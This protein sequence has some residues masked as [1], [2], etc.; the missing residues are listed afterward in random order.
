ML[1]IMRKLHNLMH[2]ERGCVLMLHCVAARPEDNYLVIT[3][4]YLEKTIHSYFQQGYEAVSIDE[5]G[6]RI[7]NHEKKR[8]VCFTFDDGYL[9]VLTLAYPLLKAWQIPF[10]VYMTRDFYRGTAKPHWNPE[11]P[12]MGVEQLL[13]LSADPLCA[14]GAHTCSHPHL[15]QLSSDE[16]RREITESK[17]DLE[18]LLGKPI[19]HIA[20]PYGDYN[21]ETL[22]IVRDLGFETAVTTSGRRVR[23]DSKLLELDRVSLIQ[24][25]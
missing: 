4:D 14:I 20:Y 2:P 10:C 7:A 9:D 5:V 16:Q 15:S 23:N 25:T 22:R 13:E 6:R 18:Q 1:R 11:A 24:K 12:M 21:Q 19:L 3:V 8:F 17:A